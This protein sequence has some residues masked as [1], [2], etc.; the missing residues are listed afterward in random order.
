MEN[1]VEKEAQELHNQLLNN[2]RDTIL[3]R[4]VSDVPRRYKHLKDVIEVV[5]D[6]FKILYD[7]SLEALP[8]TYLIFHII[9]YW[10]SHYLC[11]RLMQV[12]TPEGLAV[13]FNQISPSLR[14]CYVEDQEHFSLKALILRH[15][16]K[17]MQP[18]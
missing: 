6:A 16:E 7:P 10:T 13:H 11:R 1:E 4:L 17:M 18:Q 5:N 2:E 3:S 12:L 8:E 15:R 14:K 9:S